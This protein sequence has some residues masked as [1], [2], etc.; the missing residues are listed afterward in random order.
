[1][2]AVWED[3]EG[4]AHKVVAP[5]SLVV[6]AFAPVDDVRRHATPDLKSGDQTGLLLVDLGRGQ[7]RLGGSCLA[8]AYNQIGSG[9]P[10]VDAGDMRG[11]YEAVQNFAGPGACARVPRPVRRRDS[12][13]WLPRWR[14]RVVAAWS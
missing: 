14:L 7:N 6:S 5:L 12:L 1:M 9:I 8:Q 10:D 2:R 11:L 13:L 3:A 4:A